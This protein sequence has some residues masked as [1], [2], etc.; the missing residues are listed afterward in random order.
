MAHLEKLRRGYHEIRTFV[1]FISLCYN[2][3]MLRSAT[4]SRKKIVPRRQAR[5]LRTRDAILVRAMDIASVQGLEGLTVGSLAEQLRMSKSGLF[6]HFGSKEELQ[7]ATIEKARQTFIEQVTRPAIAARKGMPRLWKIIDLWLA[8][9]ERNVFKGGC[10]FSAA[11]FEFDSRQGVVRDRIAAIMHEWIGVITRAVYEAQKAGHVHL[12]IDP[13]RLAF[14]IHAIA[15][16]GHW[17]YQ[18]LDDEHAY[19]RVRTT[20]LEKLRSIATPACPRLP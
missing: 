14:E 12:K 19:S 10:F 8:L 13:T 5:G 20:I 4:A 9:V 6:A 16:G 1:L 17:A 2:L 7:L 18:L 15:M 3:F 11:S